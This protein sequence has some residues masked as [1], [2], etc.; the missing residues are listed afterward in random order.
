MIKSKKYTFVGP[1]VAEKIR[2]RNVIFDEIY[3]INLNN[4]PLKPS[5]AINSN[6]FSFYEINFGIFDLVGQKNDFCFSK[7]IV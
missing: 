2:I 6:T 7:Q 1:A 5:R 4:Y 3:P